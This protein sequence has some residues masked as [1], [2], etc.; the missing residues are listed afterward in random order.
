MEVSYCKLRVFIITRC[1]IALV[2]P[3]CRRYPDTILVIV[4]AYAFSTGWNF[5]PLTPAWSTRGNNVRSSQSLMTPWPVTWL[6]RP[7]FPRCQSRQVP[8]FARALTPFCSQCSVNLVSF[9]GSK[10]LRCF[11]SL[12]LHFFFFFFFCFLLSKKL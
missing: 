12:L 8:S 4:N 2:I 1:L 3:W 11:F 7:P 9:R 10:R 5:L 6:P